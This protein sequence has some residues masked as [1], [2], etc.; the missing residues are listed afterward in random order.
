MTRIA[1]VI[2]WPIEHSR[3]PAMM[4]AAFAAT[5]IDATMIAMGVPPEKLG[6]TLDGLRAMPMLGASVT[7]PHKLAVHALCDELLPAAR[8]IGAVNCLKLVDD[9]LVGDNTDALGFVDSLVHNAIEIHGARVTV[10]GGGGAARAVAYGCE[11]SGA[12]VEVVA[13]SGCTWTQ[14]RPWSELAAALARADLVV[15]CTPTGLDPDA[16]AQF[17]ATLPLDALP[18]RA[19]VVSLVYH[20]RTKLLERAS[21]LGHSTLDGREMLVFQGT[22]AF[23]WWTGRPAPFE[24]MLAA[25]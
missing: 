10:L 24:A 18:K 1:A 25:L 17:V 9:R 11:R 4:N 8:A 3:S 7:V 6:S 19:C 14:A 23:A 13:R 15:D 12:V 2:G 22:R 16:D 20:R 5:G 21:E